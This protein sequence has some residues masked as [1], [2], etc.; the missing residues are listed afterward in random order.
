VFSLWRG[1]ILVGVTSRIYAFWDVRRK[2]G[3]TM[4]A[5]LQCNSKAF[6]ASVL[7]L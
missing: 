1:R 2:T 6:D 5:T 7:L 4:D 3:S